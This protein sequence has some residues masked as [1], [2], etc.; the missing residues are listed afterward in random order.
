MIRI[1]IVEDSPEDTRRI[2]EC[3][4]YVR[5]KD[6]LE[7]S[8][9]K[10]ADADHFFFDTAADY[11]LIL[12][13]I[14]MPG[15][16]GMEAA[17]RIRQ[18][19]RMVGIVFVTNMAQLAIKGYEVDAI[20][21]IVKPV[22]INDFYLKMHHVF[23]RL[24]F[25]EKDQIVLKNGEK[26]ISIPVN[27]ILYIE[28]SGHYVTYHTSNEAFEQYSTLKETEKAMEGY[29]YIVRCSRYYLVN[30]NHVDEVRGDE[31]VV[32]GVHVPVSRAEK[33]RLKALLASH[34]TSGI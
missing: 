26:V 19:N 15:I 23:T 6:H 11:D 9:K 4:S 12:M 16:N 20:D 34:F 22:N 25:F 28:V 31:V 33:P 8:V 1:A 2:E 29:P 7:L 10:F 18:D 13:D 5:E 32:G 3:L 17:K 30:L 24:N 21:F 27:S 14:Q